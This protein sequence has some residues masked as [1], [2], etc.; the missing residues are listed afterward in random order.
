MSNFD[1]IKDANGKEYLML[2]SSELYDDTQ[3]GNK[4]EDFE[5]LK[6]L[7][8][9]SFG[10]VFKV[11]SKINNKVYAMKQINI[12]EIRNRKGERA[13]QLT[14]NETT[15]LEELSHP[16]IVKYYKNFTE[17]NYL[18]II[19]EFSAN[20]DMKSFLEAHK[21]FNKHIPEEKLWNIFLQC[22]EAL[23]Y[24]HSNGV[25][26]RD[27]KPAN[28][29]VDN[30]M[31]IKLGDFGVSAIKKKEHNLYLNAKYKKFQENKSM[32]SSNTCV[33]SKNYMAKEVIEEN[34][35]D[36]KI[37]VFSMGVTFF[38]L[39]YFHIPKKVKVKPDIHGNPII[40]FIKVEN[41]DDVNV[42][43][44]KELLDIINLMIEE[45]KN[46]RKSSEE[47]LNLIK[48]EY[49]NKY[50]KNSSIDSIMRCLY[51]F[52]KM[53]Y[54]FLK[55]IPMNYV[56]K[57]ITKAFIQCLQSFSNNDAWN[58]SIKNFRQIISSEN[59]KL[60]GTK[61]IDPRLILAF[62]FKELHKEL[63]IAPYN[64]NN[65]IKKH[66][67]ISGEETSKTSKV[68]IMLKF[69]DDI[70]QKFN[71]EISNLFLGLI[72]ITNVCNVCNIKTFSFNA[73]FFVTFNLENILKNNNNIQVLNIEEQFLKQNQN[74][75]SDNHY[76]TKC[77][78][79]TD[80]NCTKEFYSLSNLLIISIQRGIT[81]N[82]K[83]PINIAEKIDL[84]NSV[85]FQYSKKKFIL[86]GLLGR[87]FENGNERFY[88]VVKIGQIWYIYE[89]NIIKQINSPS[90]CN[91]KGD[92]IMLFYIG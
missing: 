26:H 30:N 40:E 38:E 53:T 35:Y 27:I 19:I 3:M 73:F 77:I 15:F 56:N 85:E 2:D 44:S 80:H 34:D 36:Q 18:Y 92:I 52:P 23:Y 51:S 75:Y 4:S 84:S 72:K 8:E 9:G 48:N 10:K 62:L 67:I 86:V 79:K 42:H 12:S 63:V 37:D 5:I 70:Y 61:E 91:Q 32:E 57:P 60:E 45:D 33:G 28:L 31:S 29:L 78:C 76:C 16:H 59:S 83:T 50:V 54:K 25:I 39:C 55:M 20:G 58:N 41:A 69:I 14:I 49:S 81:Y 82:Y 17:G 65:E 71:S 68:E 66:L 11:R 1:V 88:S 74:K 47:I 89:G 7:G 6:K 90:D 22:M 64:Y 43:Y 87:L 21:M 24:V 46:K 13:Y